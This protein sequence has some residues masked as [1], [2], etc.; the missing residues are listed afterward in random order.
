MGHCVLLSNMYSEAGRLDGVAGIRA[1]MRERGLR[2]V[3]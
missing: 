1:M 3:S 2:I